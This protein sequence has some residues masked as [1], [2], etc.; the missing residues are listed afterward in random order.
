MSKRSTSSFWWLKIKDS[1]GTRWPVTIEKLMQIMA[2]HW[3]TFWSMTVGCGLYTDLMTAW[4][5]GKNPSANSE[6]TIKEIPI[7]SVCWV[8]S[9]VL[10]SKTLKMI[11]P[12]VARVAMMIFLFPSLIVVSLTP[13]NSTPTSTTDKILHERTII[14]TGKL[15]NLMA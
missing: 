4:K 2:A 5:S 7:A 12:A 8:E 10:L 1:M 14:T 13:V 3:L 15:V 9:L 6:V 11:I